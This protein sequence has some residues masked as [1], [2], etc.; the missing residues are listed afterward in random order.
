MADLLG[1]MDPRWIH[2]PR[3]HSIVERKGRNPIRHDLEMVWRQGRNFIDALDRTPLLPTCIYD[4]ATRPH[5][6]QNMAVMG[7]KT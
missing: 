1:T 4:L 2:G 6:I 7:W 5:G 3:V